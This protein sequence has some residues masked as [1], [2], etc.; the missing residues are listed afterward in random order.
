VICAVAFCPHPPLLVP[1][2]AQGAAGELDDLRAA[3]REAITRIAAPGRHLVVIGAGSTS[4]Y[5]ESNV[6]G[7]LAGFGVPLEIPLGSEEPG[8][9]EL[10]LS[11]TMGGWLLRDALGPNCGA[12]GYSIGPSG[13]VGPGLLAAADQRDAEHAVLVMG[14]GSARRTTSAPGYFD[15]RAA[16]FDA[17]IAKALRSGQGDL[18]HVDVHLGAELLAS[19]ALVWAEVARLVEAAPWNAELLYDDA[20]YGVGYFVASWTTRD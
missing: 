8:P 14:D 16:A 3:C 5:Y 2:V 11:L 4:D 12:V 19:G 6:R 7:T 13:D 15:E 20:P 10:P 17:V 18:L 9:V 1:E